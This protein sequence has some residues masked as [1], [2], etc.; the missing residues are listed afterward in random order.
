MSTFWQLA[1]REAWLELAGQTAQLR[2]FR[3]RRLA[4]DFPLDAYAA[5]RAADDAPCLII[6][7]EPRAEALFE[8]GGMRLSVARGERGPLIVLSLEDRHRQ[9][10][11]LTVCADVVAA[12]SALDAPAALSHFLSRLEAWRRF[13]RERRSGLSHEE[14]IGLIGELMIVEKLI[15]V[16]ADLHA[17]WEAPADGLHDFLKEGHAIEVKTSLGPSAH[18]RIS[19]LSQLETAGLRRLDLLHVRL[20]EAADGQTLDALLGGIEAYLPDDATRRDFANALLKR[21]LMP[22]D[23]AARTS[24]R[25][26][27]RTVDGYSVQEAFPRLTHTTVPIAVSEAI[28]QIDLRAI[29]RFAIDSRT[30][31]EIFA[32]KAA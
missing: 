3:S 10:L 30:A 31:I 22:D 7:T 1:L 11:F 5:L 17:C 19:S 20:I 26:Q 8:V 25:F 16:R 15:T 24:F 13:L 4:P 18:I 29:Q 6:E 28:Y 14:T 21:G 32:G 12:A 2:E 23:R 9:D 27:L